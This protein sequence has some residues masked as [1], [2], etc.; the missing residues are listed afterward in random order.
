[1]RSPLL[2]RPGL[3]HALNLVDTTVFAQPTLATLFSLYI[4]EAAFAQL[5]FISRVAPTFRWGRAFLFKCQWSF[6][7][8]STSQL[9]ESP[10]TIVVLPPHLTPTAKPL[11]PV[12]AYGFCRSVR[13]A[14]TSPIYVRRTVYS[15]T[16]GKT[17]QG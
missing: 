14:F 7:P 11:S 8:Y 10:T 17:W 6:P 2:I 4:P 12:L 3:T 9:Q 15:A 5:H 13:F 1:M 16:T